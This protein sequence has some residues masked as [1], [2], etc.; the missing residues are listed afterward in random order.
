M[1]HILVIDDDPDILAIIKIGLT[2][3]GHQVV[4]CAQPQELQLDQI[5]FFDLIL[6]D[7]MMP[8]L[9]G[10]D[11]IQELRQRTE[12]PI[13]FLTAKTRENDILYGL[14]LGADDY[15]TKP[16]RIAELRARIKAHLRRE[17]REHYT[18]LNLEPYRFNLLQK[19]LYY[20]D[21]LVP[22]TKGEYAICEF[23][24]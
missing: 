9:N 8:Q 24:A 1:T 14:S 4:T 20:Q 19:Q 22:L 15:L 21:Q 12:I 3:D 10:Y 5:D 16:F 17:T 11:L 23:L 7:I 6:L 18:S 2:K 13:I